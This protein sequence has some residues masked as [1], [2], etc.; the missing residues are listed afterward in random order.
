MQI[1][2]TVGILTPY[3]MWSVPKKCWAEGEPSYPVQMRPIPTVTLHASGT[4]R[5]GGGGGAG[6]GDGEPGG[7]GDI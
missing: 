1:D 4:A 2:E 5:G 3:N 6:G 7:G